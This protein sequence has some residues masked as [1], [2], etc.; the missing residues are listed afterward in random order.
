MGKRLSWASH[1]D[2]KHSDLLPITGFSGRRCYGKGTNEDRLEGEL[3]AAFTG[4][5]GW[6]WGN[7]SGKPVTITLQATGN[8]SEIKRYD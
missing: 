7:R 4:S 8:Y 1:G 2:E 3:T 6:F 5:H